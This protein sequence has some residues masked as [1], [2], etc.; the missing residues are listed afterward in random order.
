VISTCTV[1]SPPA[2]SKF[3][4]VSVAPSRVTDARPVATRAVGSQARMPRPGTKHSSRS[5]CALTSI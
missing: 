3:L 5:M 4:M 1:V 2:D